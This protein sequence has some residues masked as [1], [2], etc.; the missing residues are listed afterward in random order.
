[1]KT[2]WEDLFNLVHAMSPAEKGYF[3]KFNAGFSGSDLSRYQKLFDLIGGMTLLDADL[4]EKKLRS[5]TKNIYSL[6]NF[7][8]KQ[9][10][11]SLRM[12]HMENDV[13]FLLRDSLD[14][15][16]ILNAK[17]LHQQSITLIEKGLA[18]AQEYGMTNY[19]ILFLT[20]KR[21]QLKFYAETKRN[22]L[23]HEIRTALLQQ[24]KSIINKEFIK[25]AHLRSIHWLNTYVPL[26]DPVIR[27]EAEDLYIKLKNI[28]EE[29]IAGHNEMNLQ[30]AALSN[31]CSLLGRQKEAINYQEKTIALMEGLDIRKLNRVMNYAA[32][33]YN[34]CN[35][36]LIDKDIKSSVE[37]LKKMRSIE[38]INESEQLYINAL[39][40]HVELF[41]QA[42][43]HSDYN[44]HLVERTEQFLL[45]KHPVP[46]VFYDT[47]L[48]LLNYY[49]QHNNWQAAVK[50]SF[51]LLNTDYRHSQVSFQVHVRLL[52]ILV[53]YK[54]GNLLLLPS[55]IRSTYRY[56]RTLNLQFALER[57][58][59]NFFSKLLTKSGSH[60]I[61]TLFRE[62][63]A[64]L[65]LLFQD[66]G[67]RR[68]MDVY[69]NY[70][71][72][73]GRELGITADN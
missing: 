41:L 15:I 49:I 72:W 22:Q 63:Y 48:L 31:I 12:Y 60:E 58:L 45:R 1:M 70:H 55:L 18:T 51:L 47:Q 53:H 2:S 68:V 39:A 26:R 5:T 36:T 8:Q 56:M 37:W 69:F 14:T 6:R 38:T 43:N 4:L 33:I 30:Y 19:T 10:L 42:I 3:K 59:L 34:V 29:E 27:K 28:A 62:L 71:A 20:E 65:E 23:S 17:G 11:K 57:L 16:S 21:Q 35:L 40:M 44:E 7:L 32:A 50:K 73:L 9:I 25:E 46:N 52:N 66:E 13:S 24:A 64:E 67:E 54:L 61:R